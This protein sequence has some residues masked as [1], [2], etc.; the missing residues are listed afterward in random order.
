M[1]HPRLTAQPLPQC[2]VYT[3][4]ELHVGY[5]GQTDNA[6]PGEPM[7]SKRSHLLTKTSTPFLSR[8]RR[9]RTPVLQLF[10]RRLRGTL[11]SRPAHLTPCPVLETRASPHLPTPPIRSPA[12][13][14]HAPPSHPAPPCLPPR[15]C[16]YHGPP[17]RLLAAG[18]TFSL[19]LALLFL[20]LDL[21]P[22]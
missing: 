4:E 10:P 16:L 1:R 17:T 14:T 6:V 7:R 13:S 12:L 11:P 20:Q 19:R 15:P 9:L 18:I 5:A 2:K 21:R 22:N 3:V 8:S